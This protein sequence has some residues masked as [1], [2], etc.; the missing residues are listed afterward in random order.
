MPVA[1]RLSIEGHRCEEVHFKRRVLQYHKYEVGVMSND[2]MFTYLVSNMYFPCCSFDT[3]SHLHVLDVQVRACAAIA[4]PLEQKKVLKNKEF[5]DSTFHLICMHSQC[6]NRFYKS[7]H[8]I[9]NNSLNLSSL[10]YME[11]SACKC[12][13]LACLGAYPR[14]DYILVC[15]RQSSVI[16]GICG[17]KGS[18]Q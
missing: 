14:M 18:S 15:S 6:S 1:I 9:N 4:Y 12:T 13:L 16:L 5:T 2:N 3:S 8:R 10:S 17:G 7:L 11:I